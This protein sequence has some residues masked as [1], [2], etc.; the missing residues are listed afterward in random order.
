MAGLSLEPQA[1]GQTRT[2]IRA[3]CL[4][5][6]LGTA[7][8]AAAPQPPKSPRLYVFDCG[9]LSITKEG[10]ERYHVTT[11]EVGETRMSVPCF[12]V[13]HPRGTLLWDLGVIPDAVVSA[14]GTARSNVNPTAAAVV[15]RTLS[16]QLAQIGYRP[17]DITYVAISH[18]HIDHSANLNQFAASTWLTN[19]AERR[20][21]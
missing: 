19:A 20:F 12:L 1:I 17:A 10:V 14:Q 4:A 16:S 3:L 13:A 9:V 5:A 11:A 8:S 18:A 2:M 15:S 7:L 6:A 21:M